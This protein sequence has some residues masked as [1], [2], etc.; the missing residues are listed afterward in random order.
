MTVWNCVK[1]IV[2]TMN[3]KEKNLK[4]VV[5]HKCY[6]NAPINS[7]WCDA[8]VCVMVYASVSNSYLKKKKFRI[9]I[10]R[11]D[12]FCTAWRHLVRVVLWKAWAPK[13]IIFSKL[14]HR[15]GRHNYFD[16]PPKEATDGLW[17]DTSRYPISCN[18]LSMCP[19]FLNSFTCSL[20]DCIIWMFKCENGTR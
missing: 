18:C 12:K 14:N 10:V 15:V 6:S 16:W 13:M 2:H 1:C 17:S 19:W 3:F 9:T 5:I 8:C 4:L 20:S 7:S 11:T